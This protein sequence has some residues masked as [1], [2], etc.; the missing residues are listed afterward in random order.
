MYFLCI[1]D[2][3]MPIADLKSS[4]VV[5]PCVS[6]DDPRLVFANIEDSIPAPELLSSDDEAANLTLDADAGGFLKPDVSVKLGAA[7]KRLAKKKK[8]I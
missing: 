6:E 3:K 5:L 7:P 8:G 1:S 4:D 2:Q